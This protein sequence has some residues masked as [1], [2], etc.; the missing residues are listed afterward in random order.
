MEFLG[1]R[2]AACDVAALEQGNRQTCLGQVGGAG[3]AIV[4]RADDRYVE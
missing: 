3:Q 2:C 1:D 4:T